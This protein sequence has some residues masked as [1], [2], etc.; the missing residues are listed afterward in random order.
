MELTWQPGFDIKTKKDVAIKLIHDP[1]QELRLMG[2]E[3]E[4]SEAV[5]S[6]T[7]MPKIRW[8]GYEEEYYVLVYDLLGPS[9]EDLFEFCGQ[10][11]NLKTVLL[12]AE[13]ALARLRYMHGKKC[14]HCD[15]KPSN[16]L[17]GRGRQGSLLYVTD[18]GS[19]RWVHDT[20]RRSPHKSFF[21][22]TRDYTSVS[23]DSGYGT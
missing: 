17:M 15:I 2:S 13:Q 14:L 12:I 21:N 6:G 1:T 8:S 22:G 11:F 18:F 19:A 20:E 4:V 23:H 10:R 16:L 7:G 3:A 5:F 9:L